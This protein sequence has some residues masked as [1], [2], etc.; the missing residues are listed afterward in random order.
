M[1]KLL[2]IVL[3][4]ALLA[5]MSTAAFAETYDTLTEAGISETED[6][7]INVTAEGDEENADKVYKVVITWDELTFNFVSSV[8]ADELTYDPE[9]HEY[10]NMAGNWEKTSARVTVENHSN[11]EVVVDAS[12]TNDA[13]A[14]HGVTATLTG[15][16]AA[17]ELKSALGLSEAPTAS[18]EVSVDGTPGILNFTI[19]TVEVTINLPAL[20]EPAPEP[21]P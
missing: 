12:M 16:E 14:V 9:T 5:A 4:L 15:D 6:V 3:T 13:V 1:K 19:G 7:I 20:E 8:S 11:A 21:V 18:Y 2:A 10:E 17:Q